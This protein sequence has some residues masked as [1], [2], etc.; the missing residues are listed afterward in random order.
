M[1][2]FKYLSTIVPDSAS[3]PMPNWA[4]VLPISIQIEPDAHSRVAHNVP[5]QEIHKEMYSHQVFMASYK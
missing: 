4:S 5:C 2:T 1:T 3:S